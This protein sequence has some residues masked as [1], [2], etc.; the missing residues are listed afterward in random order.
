MSTDWSYAHDLVNMYLGIAHLADHELHA[1]EERI[2]SE[3][4]REW[5]PHMREESFQSIWSDV[6]ELYDS[7]GSDDNR[8]AVFLQST[9][10]VAE[11][12]DDSRDQLK[13]IIRDLAAIAGADGVL[14]DN[15]ATMIKATACVYGLDIELDVDEET[16]VVSVD[17][18]NDLG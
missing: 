6:R 15:E 14:R 1:E 18:K 16:N 7:L 8:Y 17:F 5:M 13:Y 9:L 10:K 12:L 11:L 3:R 4:F 2:F